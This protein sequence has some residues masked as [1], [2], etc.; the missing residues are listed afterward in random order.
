MIDI[1]GSIENG[2]LCLEKGK[3]ERSID[4]FHKTRSSLAFDVYCVIE[5]NFT[6]HVA[7][8]TS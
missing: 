7:F 6:A 5:H 2:F 4:P 8:G 3:H 1:L